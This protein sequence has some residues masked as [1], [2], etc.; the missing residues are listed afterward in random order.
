LS[1]DPTIVAVIGTSC[2]SAARVAIPLMSNAGFSIISASNTAPDLT[3]AGNEN[4]YP[5]YLRTATMIPF[6]ALPRL[7][8]LMRSRATGRL[9]IHDGSLY[10]DKLQQVFAEEFKRLG[11]EI[12]SQEAVDPAATDMVQSSPVSQPALQS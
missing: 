6:R 12:T 1:A 7:S 4:N 2:S 3:E 9:T 8:S 10:A 5:G 11:G